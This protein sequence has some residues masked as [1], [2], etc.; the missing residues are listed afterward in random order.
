MELSEVDPDG[1]RAPQACT[2][3]APERQLR[4]AEFDGLF[5]EVVLGIK[6]VDAGRL[7]LDLRPSPK[8]AGR[9][10]ELVA[11]ETG[12]CSFFTFTLTAAAGR[13]ALEIAVPA[14][15]IAV[16]DALADRAVAAAGTAA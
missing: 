2:L 12:C 8:V 7:R 16:L 5:A 6:R 10:A 13:L 3:L 4:A 15:H 1:A 14:P 9:A 11:A